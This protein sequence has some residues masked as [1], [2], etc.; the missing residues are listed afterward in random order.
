MPRID[1]FVKAL[2]GLRGIAVLYVVFSHLGRLELVPF[3][4][5]GRIGKMGVMIF[6]VLSAFLLT[7]K[8]SRELAQHRAYPVI[9]T[10]LIHRLFRIYPLFLFVLGLHIWVGNIDWFTAGQNVLLQAGFRELWAIPVEFKYYF[11]MPL[12]A[13]LAVRLGG[14]ATIA[15]LLIGFVIA[16]SYN[17]AYPGIGLS[18]SIVLVE[19]LAPFL[20]G[21]A[22]ALI[23]D[24]PRGNAAV[25]SMGIWLG[26]IA[27]SVLAVATV[28]FHLTHLGRPDVEFD[29]WIL[30]AIIFAASGLIAV[31]LWPNLL[32][33]VL[34]SRVLVFFGEI[35]FSLYLLHEFLIPWAVHL[36]THHV[37]EEAWIAFLAAV[38]VAC[39]S[40]YCIERPCIKLGYRIGSWIMRRNADRA[41][42]PA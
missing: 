21:S 8:L 10:Y 33:R 17:F 12:I 15:L 14:R 40:Y 19:R 34:A 5:Y 23:L 6:F 24:D 37:V 31:S 27:V 36:R 13:L 3:V 16:W 39:V 26:W 9:G 30:L 2:H 25:R 1:S 7:G 22:L 20:G 32:S 42:D 35:S 38:A 4:H 28:E 29:P 18:N 11:C 41:A